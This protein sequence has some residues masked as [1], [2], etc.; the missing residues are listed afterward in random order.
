MVRVR[1]DPV[2][3]GPSSHPD[4]ALVRMALADAVS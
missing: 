1:I 4:A 3:R 2:K